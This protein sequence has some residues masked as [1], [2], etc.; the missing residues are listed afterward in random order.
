MSQAVVRKIGV[1]QI[2]AMSDAEFLDLVLSIQSEEQARQFVKE[3]DE[4]ET[5]VFS[6]KRLEHLEDKVRRMRDTTYIEIYRMGHVKVLREIS[7]TLPDACAW[8]LSL[9]DEEAEEVINAYSS[10]D[11]AYD[12]EVLWPRKKERARERAHRAP[13]RVRA[14]IMREYEKNGRVDISRPAVMDRF[15]RGAER[16]S[17]TKRFMDDYVDGMRNELLKARAVSIGDGTYINRDNVNELYKAID[18]RI[19]S[20]ARDLHSLEELMFTFD[21]GYRIPVEIDKFSNQNTRIKYESAAWLALFFSAGRAVMDKV[22]WH[23]TTNY[24]LEKSFLG[25]VNEIVEGDDFDYWAAVGG[26]S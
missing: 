7:K 12:F 2:E 17:L 9:S 21:R 14:E 13:E 25:V 15:K 5:L 11:S 6:L 18:I 20:V 4:L 8:Y 19:K 3:M 26:A 10:L 22:A 23:F 24:V 16:D 1:G